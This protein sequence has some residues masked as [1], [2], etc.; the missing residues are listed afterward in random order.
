[1][2]NKKEPAKEQKPV[3]KKY[4]DR[5]NRS[6]VYSVLDGAFATSMVGFGESFFS[7]FAVFL[8]ATNI[9]LGLLSSLPQALGSLFQLFSNKLIKLFGSRKNLVCTFALLQGLMYIPVALVFFLGT[10]RIYHLILFICIY[11]IFGMILSPAWNSWMGDLVPE[12]KRG[13]Y[14]GRRNNITGFAYFVTFLIAGYILQRYS[15]GFVNEYIGFVVIFLLALMCRVV[16]FVF[17]S[18]KYEPRYEVAK[19]DEFSFFDFLKRVRF[20]NYGLF[21]IFLC[22]MNFSVC[23]ASPFFTPYMLNDLK[24]SYFAFTIVTAAAIITKI[25]SMPVWGRVSDRFGTKKVL[26]LSGFLMPTMPLLWL[27]SGNLYYL[28]VIQMCSGFVWAG[29][30]LASFNFIFDTT[31]PEKRATCVAYYNVLNGLAILS[32]ALIGSLIVKYNTMFWSKYLLVFLISFVLRYLVSFI[33][34][35]RLKEVRPVEPIPY[36]RLFMRI[37]TMMPTMSTIHHLIYLS[38]HELDKLEKRRL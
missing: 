28:I 27:F 8:K 32:G 35:P 22:L 19:Q 29:F 30:E 4:T 26:S 17:L 33:L 13:L 36:P 2:L 3:I 9:Q 37:I 1:M 11:W 10:L 14:F 34:I 21:V 20:S 5:V 24:M 38:K 31:S 6:L 15:D 12:N 25:S 23:L 18:K 16:S 7:V